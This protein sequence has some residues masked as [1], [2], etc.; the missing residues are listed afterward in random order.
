MA[1]ALFQQEIPGME[2]LPARVNRLQQN[3]PDE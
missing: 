2:G 1:L 3:R